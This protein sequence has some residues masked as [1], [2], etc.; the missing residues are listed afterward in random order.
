MLRPRPAGAARHAMW[1]L[2]SV[3]RIVLAS[4]PAEHLSCG[5]AG[6]VCAADMRR[7]TRGLACGWG[8]PAERLGW[9]CEDRA[10]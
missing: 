5:G 8:A 9:C 7:H 10:Q 6:C 1:P 4:C 3:L 2:R